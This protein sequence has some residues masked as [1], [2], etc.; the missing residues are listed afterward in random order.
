MATLEEADRC[1]KYLNNSV[2]EGRVITVEKV[3]TSFHILLFSACFT[4]YCSNHSIQHCI[5]T[6]NTTWFAISSLSLKVVCFF[7]LEVFVAAG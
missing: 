7:P 6:F 3:N 4:N 2:I 5:S 1:I